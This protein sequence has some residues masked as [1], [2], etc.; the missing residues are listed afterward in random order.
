MAIALGNVLE[1]AA[2]SIEDDSPE[3]PRWELVSCS[4]RLLRR[5]GRGAALAE[6]S[7]AALGARIRAEDIATAVWIAIEGWMSDGRWIGDGFCVQLVW[8]VVQGREKLQ[9][10]VLSKGATCNFSPS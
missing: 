1:K 7:E 4:W 3:I 6:R 2:M 5:A 8:L 10:R 9:S